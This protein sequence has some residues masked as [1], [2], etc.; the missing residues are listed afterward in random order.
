MRCK[1][2]SIVSDVKIPHITELLTNAL[3]LW[4]IQQRR[5]LSDIIAGAKRCVRLLNSHH[6]EATQKRPCFS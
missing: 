4:G 2:A 5:L 1:G 3:L 6:K